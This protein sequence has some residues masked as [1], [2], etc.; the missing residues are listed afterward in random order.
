[1]QQARRL[2]DDSAYRRGTLFGFTLAEIVLLIV[3]ALL[4]ALTALIVTQEKVIAALVA[5]NKDMVRVPPTEAKLIEAVKNA[6]RADGRAVPPPDELF[7]E[8]R[9]T[10]ERAPSPSMNVTDPRLVAAAARLGEQLKGGSLKADGRVEIEVLILALEPFLRRAQE[11][12][13]PLIDLILVLLEHGMRAREDKGKH[14]QQ[15]VD[16]MKQIDDLRAELAVTGKSNLPPIVR[17]PTTN[18][19]SLGKATLLLEFQERLTDTI[20]PDLRKKGDEH[21]IEVIEV[22]G[23]TD[24]LPIAGGR[25]NLDTALLPFLNRKGNETDLVAGDNAGLGLARAAAVARVLRDDQRLANFRILPLSGGQAVENDQQI[26]AGSSSVDDPSR[27]RI[28]IRMR[29]LNIET[30]E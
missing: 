20:I 18:S 25:S 28:E 16:L 23:H 3:F 15:I 9:L 5:E 27:R 1:M 30:R 21:G 26:S 24:E 4:L 8:L 2:G 22:V 13:K 14:G 6:Y 7:R 12:K 17:I 19:F 29:R 11:E 10:M